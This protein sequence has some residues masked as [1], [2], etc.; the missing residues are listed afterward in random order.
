MWVPELF[1]FPLFVMQDADLFVSV[2]V[3]VLVWL[4]PAIYVTEHE[5]KASSSRHMWVFANIAVLSTK[6][7][8]ETSKQSQSQ[9]TYQPSSQAK[10]RTA[11]GGKGSC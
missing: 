9:A 4:V 5:I 6:R 3:I 7:S 8:N 10:I 2:D 11:Q 1:K